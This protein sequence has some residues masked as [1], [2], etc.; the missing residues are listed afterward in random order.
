M[1]I[2]HTLSC[3]YMSI[4]FLVRHTPTVLFKVALAACSKSIIYDP[5]LLILLRLESSILKN[6]V[7]TCPSNLFFIALLYNLYFNNFMF[8][9]QHYFT[10]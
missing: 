10:T 6:L 9:V 4:A 5:L 2:S 1:L 7:P 3:L 8:P